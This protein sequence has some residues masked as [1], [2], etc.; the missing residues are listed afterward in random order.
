LKGQKGGTVTGIEN[1]VS[2]LLEVFPNPVSS[3]ER[4]TLQVN[5]SGMSTIELMDV[6]GRVVK[7][8]YDGE[9]TAPFSKNIE[10]STLSKGMYFIRLRL[11]GK[12]L[13]RKIFMN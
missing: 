6:T 7:H 9:I 2:N 1:P 5:E 12:V 3:S 13:V 11:D 4:L 10:T 8:V